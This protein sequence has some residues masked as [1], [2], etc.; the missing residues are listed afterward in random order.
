MYK[1][2][3]QGGLETLQERLAVRPTS[4][5]LFC[6]LFSKTVQSHRDLPKVYNLSLIHISTVSTIARRKRNSGSNKAK[7][8]S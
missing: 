7:E 4:E 5:T 8:N 1:R 6:E 2:Q 3:T